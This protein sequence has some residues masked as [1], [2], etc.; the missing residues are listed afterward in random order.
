[1]LRVFSFLILTILN[2]NEKCFNSSYR[3]I[4]LDLIISICFI[5]LYTYNT[6]LLVI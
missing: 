6:A 2:I 3:N 4:T 5:I 1:M